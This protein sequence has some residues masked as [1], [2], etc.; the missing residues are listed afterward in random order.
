MQVGSGVQIICTF[1]V[2]LGLATLGFLSPA[3]RGALL[4]TT[5][6]EG[7]FTWCTLPFHHVLKHIICSFVVTLGLATLG[8]LSPASR[9]ALLATTVGEGCK[10]R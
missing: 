10:L 5:I 6:G 4:T 1:V 3:S 2:T 8:S 9:G 7:C